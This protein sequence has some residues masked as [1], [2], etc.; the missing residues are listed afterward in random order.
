VWLRRLFRPAHYVLPIEHVLAVY[1]WPAALPLAVR[2]EH[3]LPE[4][5][6]YFEFSPRH[7]ERFLSELRAMGYPVPGGQPAGG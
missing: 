4:H 1:G 3:D 2:I 6:I 7:R 5:P